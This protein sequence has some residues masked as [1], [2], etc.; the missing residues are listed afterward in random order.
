MAAVNVAKSFHRS[1]LAAI[2]RGMK[3]KGLSSEFVD[4]VKD[5][6]ETSSTVLT[7]SSRFVGSPDSRGKTRRH[8]C[9]PHFSTY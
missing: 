9:H 4:Y 5:L 6:Y 1:S 7:M 8:V 2:L 3:C